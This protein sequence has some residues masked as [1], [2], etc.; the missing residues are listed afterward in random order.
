MYNK[1]CKSQRGD[2]LRLTGALPESTPAII[3]SVIEYPATAP[4]AMVV[5]PEE[6]DQTYPAFYFENCYVKNAIALEPSGEFTL[7][8]SGWYHVTHAARTRRTKTIQEPVRVSD[9]QSGTWIAWT[10]KDPRCT[11]KDGQ[12]FFEGR[13]VALPDHGTWKADGDGAE[14]TL[15]LGEP[16][17]I[18]GRAAFTSLMDGQPVGDGPYWQQMRLVHNYRR[19]LGFDTR[20]LVSVK[21]FGAVGDGVA[22]DT[23]ALRRAVASGKNLLLPHGV[24]RTL[25]SLDLKPGQTLV[26]V[27]KCWSVIAGAEVGA[28]VFGGAARN[29]AAG[30]A[31]LDHGVPV[32]ATA[33]DDAAGNTLC[34]LGLSLSYGYKEAKTR[35]DARVGGYLLLIQGG[36]CELV[37]VAFRVTR[38]AWQ[39]R[40]AE[41][42]RSPYGLHGKQRDLSGVMEHPQLQVTA[43]GGAKI[44]NGC[45]ID[46]R[47]YPLGGNYLLLANERHPVMFYHLQIQDP[48]GYGLRMMGSTGGMRAYG[49]KSEH[50]TACLLFAENSRNFGWYGYGAGGAP[51]PE[52]NSYEGLPAANYR[53]E[54]CDDF[55]VAAYSQRVQE[56]NYLTY[57]AIRE[58]RDGAVVPL[59]RA[60]RPILYLRGKPGFCTRDAGVGDVSYNTE[61]VRVR[62]DIELGKRM[63]QVPA[64]IRQSLQQTPSLEV[65][66]RGSF[67]GDDSSTA[68]DELFGLCT[69]LTARDNRRFIHLVNYRES[70]TMKN[71]VIRL[72]VG[73]PLRVKSVT[74]ASPENDA[75]Q[76]A[77]FIEDHECVTF[78]VPIVS[79]YTVAVV[80]LE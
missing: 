20:G 1:G 28:T 37:D 42:S 25:G 66:T 19:E 5:K 71:L 26:G 61:A 6:R 9:Q 4:A 47:L 64:A 54:N 22:D 3:D 38:N 78:R 17:V 53:I 57:D 11:L 7:C 10:R 62:K 44:Y 21:D 63:G 67:A 23:A 41:T 49:I 13:P 51:R 45:F 74:L 79:V 2:F 65:C 56:R 34:D 24:Y 75:D 14:A 77:L 35:E 33:A 46:R 31:T 40:G 68:K 29:T 32:V 48:S 30:K 73:A 69:E 60:F 76:T 59:D 36:G 72:R 80:E 52:Q 18:N 12:L 70:A 58:V 16:V 27:D 55:L 43:A 8:R 15:F 50:G 39:E